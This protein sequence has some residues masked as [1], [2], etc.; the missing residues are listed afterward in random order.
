MVTDPARDNVEVGPAL[1]G[2][3]TILVF[4][5]NLLGDSICRLPA[6]EAASKSYPGSRVMV[7]ADPR[8]REVFE[9]QPFIDEVWVLDR[10]GSRAAQATAWLNMIRRA[11]RA[12]P[13]LVLDLY[14]SKRTALVSRLSGARWRAG[15]H[16]RGRSRWY[17]LRPSAPLSQSGHIIQQMNAAVA[18]AGIAAEF[19]YVPI[20]VAGE[21]HPALCDIADVSSS[22]PSPRAERVRG[23]EVTAER[24]EG[25]EVALVLLNPSARVKAKR[26]PAERFGQLAAALSGQ[27]GLRCAVI[28]A[29]GEERLV[30]QVVGASGGAAS[31][32]PALTIKQLAALVEMA[33]LVV[34]GDTGVLHLATAMGEPS[35]ILA[36]PTDPGMVAYPGVRQAVLFHREAC[37][38]WVSGD[39]CARYNECNER[40]C[41][42]AIPVDEVVAAV[43]A[44]LIG[45]HP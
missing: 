1:T 37:A 24:A 11:R 2:V 26:W 35:V 42:D 32:L 3:R 10:T 34:T 21:P 45:T 6:M 38:K 9:G 23:G 12:R 25:G 29:P 22:G 13:E 16:R 7:V 18:A 20:A 44:L 4:A 14:G 40:Q 43:R 27:A 39:E 28:T 17:S 19:R 8:Y 31:A 33:V 15:L 36:G 30:G 41:I 5:F